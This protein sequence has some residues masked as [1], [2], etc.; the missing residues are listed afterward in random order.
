MIPIVLLL[1]PQ[2]SSKGVDKTNFLRLILIKK[3]T[4]KKTINLPV[5]VGPGFE[6]QSFSC[7]TLPTI[8]I[9]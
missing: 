3:K 7:T 4:K 6:E 8:L 5:A 9:V 2:F 1:Y